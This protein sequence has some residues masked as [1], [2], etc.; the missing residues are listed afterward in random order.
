MDEWRLI[1]WIDGWMDGQAVVK[2]IDWL[3]ME[4]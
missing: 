4:G 2:F 3:S 1:T